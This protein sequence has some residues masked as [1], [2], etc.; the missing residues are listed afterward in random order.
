MKWLHP[1]FE[2]KDIHSIANL[3]PLAASCFLSPRGRK[4]L[5]EIRKEIVGDLYPE[6][7]TG[8]KLNRDEFKKHL[9]GMIKK[10]NSMPFR[11]SLLLH[12]AQPTISIPSHWAKSIGQTEIPNPVRCLLSK[13]FWPTQDGSR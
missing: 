3:G 13:R 2:V 4:K 9:E 5:Y 10:I 7:A 6:I 8:R 11:P 1:A 12:D